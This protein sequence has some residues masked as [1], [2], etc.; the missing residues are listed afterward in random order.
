MAR[1]ADNK[2]LER[3]INSKNVINLERAIDLR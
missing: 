3:A 1:K 2:V